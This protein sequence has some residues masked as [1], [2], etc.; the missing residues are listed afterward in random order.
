M[1]DVPTK[2][3]CKCKAQKMVTEYHRNRGSHDGLNGM[4]KDCNKENSRLQ[5]L[6]DREHLCELQRAWTARTSERRKPE[7]AAYYQLHREEI[8]ER[9]RSRYAEEY[10]NNPSKYLVKYHK[11]RAI[12]NDNGGSYTEEEWQELCAKYGNMCLWC[13]RKVKLTVDHIIPISRGGTNDI[14][15]LQPLCRSCN[16]RKSD[17]IIDL[18]RWY[19]KYLSVPEI[20]IE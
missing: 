12:L 3:C 17:R 2:Q 20:E 11:R 13:E 19:D 6:R 10:P 7:K 14:D 9:A 5:R 1:S 8:R 18:R 15:N 16:C 4:C